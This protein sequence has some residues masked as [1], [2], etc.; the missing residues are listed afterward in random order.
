MSKFCNII[1]FLTLDFYPMRQLHQ[2]GYIQITK[3][4]IGITL[5]QGLLTKA[6]IFNMIN[7]I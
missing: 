5:C 1:A 4:S 6:H 7:N 2:L 3:G